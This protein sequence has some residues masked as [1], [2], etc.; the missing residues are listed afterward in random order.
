MN[1]MVQKKR[2][3]F[4]DDEPSVL[5]SVR[6]I[7]FDMADVW[8]VSCAQSA[9]EA[10]DYMEEHGPVDVIIS[11]MRMPGMDGAALLRQV[12]ELYPQTI[13]FILSGHSDQ[14]I[15]AEFAERFLSKPCDADTIKA[16]IQQALQTKI[17]R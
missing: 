14:H 17:S 13:R 6:R 1:D 5:G 9:Y 7:F 15:D 11:D 10:L 12:R 4:V 2:I 8:D 16:A 3:L